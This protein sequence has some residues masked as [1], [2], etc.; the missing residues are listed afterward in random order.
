L[1]GALLCFREGSP[2]PT[3][4]LVA[5]GVAFGIAGSVKVFAIA[6]VFGLVAVLALKNRRA[7]VPV[8]AGTA[9]GFVVVCLP[10]F[11]AAP[12]GFIHDVINSQFGRGTAKPTPFSHRVAAVTGLTWTATAADFALGPDSPWPTIA[13]SLA[14]A[15]L[16]LGG[17]VP[18]ALRRGSTFTWF[19]LVATAATFGLILVPAQFFDH[20]AYLPAVFLALSLGC[21]TA[22]VGDLVTKANPSRHVA[23]ID[24]ATEIDDVRALRP[25]PGR[26]HI[27]AGSLALVAIL[28]GS[29]VVLHITSQ[30]QRSRI[31]RFGDPGP[32]IDKAIP[33]GACAV[34]DAESILI[35]ANRVST[36]ANC[37]IVDDST[38]TWLSFDP[39]NPPTRVT[40]SPKDPALVAYWQQVLSRV[41]YVTF[42]GRAAFRIPF[43]RALRHWFYNHF[44]QAPGPSALTY[45]RRDVPLTGATGSSPF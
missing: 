43:T 1:I 37:P 13:G 6:V 45:V 42:A 44:S 18:A 11:A 5:G 7:V 34:S 14:A 8:V 33:A 3:R 41:T 15:A 19:C 2:A 30:Y 38:G 35:A 25:K 23:S 29:G 21:V 17:V 39:T 10:F 22:N 9:I 4:W 16:L 24:T 32:A 40:S 26:A 36:A 28:G 12:H 31:I 27:I 20:Y